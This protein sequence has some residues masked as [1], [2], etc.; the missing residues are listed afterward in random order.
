MELFLV[1]SPS[2]F[3][4]FFSP[5][6]NTYSI[7]KDGKIDWNRFPLP[8]TAEASLDLASACVWCLVFIVGAFL[9]APQSDGT[10]NASES[11][12]EEEGV[13]KGA[14]SRHLDEVVA[15]Q[16]GAH[17]V[18]QRTGDDGNANRRQCAGNALEAEL[19]ASAKSSQSTAQKSDDAVVLGGEELMVTNVPGQKSG[20]CLHCQ[21]D[22]GERGETK[23]DCD[24][25]FGIFGDF[26]WVVQYVGGKL[27]S[28]T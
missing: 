2:R 25:D 11:A 15:V 21:D 8:C 22:T 17:A 4:V 19:Q 5:Y 13:D 1:G 24:S 23:G 6:T 9:F 12:E 27:E 7:N 28:L 3:L 14:Q 16:Q 10:A 18:C 26:H 20:G